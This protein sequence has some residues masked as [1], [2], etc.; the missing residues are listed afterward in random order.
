MYYHPSIVNQHPKIKQLSAGDIVEHKHLPGVALVI[1]EGPLEG[2]RGK[3]WIVVG[4]EGRKES[5][6]EVNLIR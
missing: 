1:T 2:V 5:V 6:L 4:P 3:R